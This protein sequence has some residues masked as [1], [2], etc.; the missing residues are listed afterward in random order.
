MVRRTEEEKQQEQLA[1]EFVT[2]LQKKLSDPMIENLDKFLNNQDYDDNMKASFRKMLMIT[3]GNSLLI[4]SGA[5]RKEL[6]QAYKG[7]IADYDKLK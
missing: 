5:S 1:I 7:L 2:D 4:K 3:I 6:K